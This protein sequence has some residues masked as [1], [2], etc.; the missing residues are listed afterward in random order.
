MPVFAAGDLP[1]LERTRG[2]RS[3]QQRRDAA[4]IAVFQATGMRLPELAGMQG[5]QDQDRQ[6]RPRRRPQPRPVPPRP[7][8]ARPGMPAAAVARHQQPGSDDRQRHLPGHR[9]PRPLVRHRRVP[10]PVPAPL[11]PH[12]AR[13]RRG[14]GRPHGA[15]QLDLPADAPPPRRQRPQRQGTPQLRPRHGGRT[16]TRARQ[17]RRRRG[18]CHANASHQGEISAVLLAQWTRGAREL[19]RADPGNLAYYG[20]RLRLRS[21]SAECSWLAAGRGVLQVTA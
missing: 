19:S 17:G 8:P 1:R 9:P 7:R 4:V 16:L 13:P 11:Q 10:A 21:R 6:D 12:L 14:R 3:F 15:Q 2:G 20:L 18:A 5:P